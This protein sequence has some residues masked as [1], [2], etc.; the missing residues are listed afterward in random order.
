MRPGEGEGDGDPVTRRHQIV[1]GDM[2]VEKR[3]AVGREQRLELCRS[4]QFL[5]RGAIDVVRMNKIVQ[6]REVAV[7]D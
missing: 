4:V 6:D 3:R 1:D 5:A 2:Q 7:V